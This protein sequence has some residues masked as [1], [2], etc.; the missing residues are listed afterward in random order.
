MALG[1][2]AIGEPLGNNP[3]L[4]TIYPHLK[5]QFGYT[6]PDKLVA[7]AIDLVTHAEKARELGALNAAMFDRYLAPRPTAEYVHHTL[8][9]A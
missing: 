2:A 1:T 4:L 5:E 9:E 8:H 6:D 3:E 7:H